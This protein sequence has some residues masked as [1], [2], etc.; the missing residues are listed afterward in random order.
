MSAAAA[1]EPNAASALE[2]GGLTK[3][4]GD[5]S[6]AT[7]LKSVSLSVAAGEMFVVMGES[8]SGKSTMVRCVTRLLEPTEGRVRV[9][10]RDV[11]AMDTQE[12]VDLRRET[13]AMVFQ[14]HGLLPHRTVMHNVGFG[15]EL[16]GINVSERQERAAE[17]VALVGLS[18]RGDAYPDELSGGMQQR[19]GIARALVGRP[20]LL[21]MD[22]PFSGLDPLLRA[23]MQR[24]L[25]GI[26][27]RLGTT[28]VFITHDAREA[29]AL[30]SRVA[31]MRAGEVVQQGTPNELET[32]P[33]DEFV[34]RLI[35]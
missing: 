21:L 26:Q 12:L 11:M 3:V 31:L 27:D 5:A 1:L 10:G 24:E 16:R 15:L 7:A 19:V 4:Y 18:G 22:E 17:M 29:F 13:V 6:P 34:R 25:L 35:A 30:G 20:S 23:Q 14:S 28:V 32:E 9:H 33:A 2:L 8:G